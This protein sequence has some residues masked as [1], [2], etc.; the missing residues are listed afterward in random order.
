MTSPGPGDLPE[1]DPFDLPD[2]LGTA[3]VTWEPESGI[4]TGHR[5]KGR[6]TAGVGD[7]ELPCDLLA[8]DEAYPVPVADDHSRLR[9]HQAWR[10][11]EILLVCSEG[12]LTLAVPGT[13]FTADGVL[14][15]LSRLAKAVGAS[16][17]QYAAR[18][19]IGGSRSGPR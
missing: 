15:A 10:H 11:G 7:D 17:D 19:R 1:A 8:V 5:V 6:L 12:R 13:S 14:D 9:A 16:A 4:R 3:E 18:L 2:W